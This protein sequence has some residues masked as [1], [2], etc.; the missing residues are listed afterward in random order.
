LIVSSVIRLRS[1]RL[2]EM[3]ILVLLDL[4]Q[5]YVA[6]PRI[7]ALPG[8]HAA[9][10]KCRDALTAARANGIPVAF[11]RLQGASAFFNRSS[12]LFDWVEGFEPLRSEM[13]FDRELP[14]CYSS[15][16]FAAFMK[17]VRAPV[18]IAGFSGESACLAT[19]VDG[20]HRRQQM[21]YLADASASQP[22]NGLDCDEV[23][24][25]VAGIA[26]VYADIADTESWTNSLAGPRQFTRANYET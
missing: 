3:P 6:A 2:S 16:G 8:A 17:D 24:R 19:L 13:V 9:L 15:E 20:Y 26:S 4:Q 5:E 14:S 11:T 7:T 25:A 10:R 12:K 22:L 1:Q 18:V 21:I 23:Q